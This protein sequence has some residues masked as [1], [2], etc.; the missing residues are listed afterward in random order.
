[1]LAGDILRTKLVVKPG[2]VERTGFTI[3]YDY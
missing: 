1:V 3:A 2:A